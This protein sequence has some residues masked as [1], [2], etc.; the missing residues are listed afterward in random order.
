MSDEVVLVGIMS[1]DTFEARFPL[2]EL[3]KI[4]YDTL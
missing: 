1:E 4:F 2:R 3:R